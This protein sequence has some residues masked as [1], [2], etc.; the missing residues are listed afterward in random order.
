MAD[1]RAEFIARNQGMTNRQ[2]EVRD[3]YLEDENVLEKRDG[4][5]PRDF[6]IRQSHAIREDA[7]RKVK[8]SAA[9]YQNTRE[10][11]I[12]KSQRYARGVLQPGQALHMGGVVT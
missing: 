7:P 11:F 1:P 5:Q 8:R 10:D 2:D 9:P 4:E 12:G 6:F 3:E